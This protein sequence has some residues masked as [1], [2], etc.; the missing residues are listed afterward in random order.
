VQTD[1]VVRG[2]AS[3]DDVPLEVIDLEPELGPSPATRERGPRRRTIV[4][5]GAAA[6]VVLVVAISIAS[7]PHPEPTAKPQPDAATGRFVP[8]L[9]HAGRVRLR[10]PSDVVITMTGNMSSTMRGLGATFAGGI[11]SVAFRIARGDPSDLFDSLG[12]RPVRTAVAVAG[13]DAR[14]PDLAEFG[15]HLAVL[16]GGGWTV[17]AFLSDDDRLAAQQLR[18]VR[19]WRLRPTPEGAVVEA[20]VTGVGDASVVL[21]SDDAARRRIELTD[22]NCAGTSVRSEAQLGDVSTGYWCEQGVYVRITGP[23]GFVEPALSA[24]RVEVSRSS[25]PS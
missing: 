8:P 5:G 15:G 2:D 13:S 18:D 16:S 20:P 17:V 22:D 6:V 10:L 24:L 3:D 4:I 1:A 14:A 12:S 19:A 7:R 23:P 21:V 25:A 11:G 9:D